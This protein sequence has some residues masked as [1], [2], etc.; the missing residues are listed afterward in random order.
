MNVYKN[1]N[2]GK[3]VLFSVSHAIWVICILLFLLGIILVPGFLRVNNF[4][5]ILWG[6]VSFGFMVLG[7]FFVFVTGGMDLSIES[8]FAIAPIIGALAMQRWLPGI[9]SPPVAIIIILLVG[10][11]V[12][13][14]NASLHVL[15]GINPFLVTL[16][17]LIILRGLCAFLIPEGLYYLPEGFIALGNSRVLNFPVA[18]VVFIIAVFVVYVIVKKTE[19]GRNLYAVGSSEK[20]AFLFG[21][22][23]GKVKTIAFVLAGFFAALGGL[24]AAGRMQA[25]IPD[26]GDGDIIT[27]FAAC[28]LGG[29]SMNGGKG[30]L[31]DLIG[32][33][34]ALSMITNLLNLIGVNPF[35]VKVIYGMILLLAIIFANAQQQFKQKMLLHTYRQGKRS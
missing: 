1:N 33:I 18:V 31:V 26:M 22:K 15:L 32:S 34:L 2:L 14:I 29:M 13:L 11:V 30:E 16:G 8:T 7:I 6:N 24:T 21:I 19:F 20:A 23:V 28:F 9:V 35:L 25:V 4:I 27:V 5:N 10:C 17:M 3:L 12:G